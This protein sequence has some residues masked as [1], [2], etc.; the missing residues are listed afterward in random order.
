[1]SSPPAASPAFDAIDW[2]TWEPDLHA[3]LLFVVRDGRILLIDKK[4]GLGAGKLNGAGGKLDPGETPHE[5][6]VREFEEELGV[7]P[8]DPIQLGRLAFAV[9]EGDSIMIHVFRSDDVRGIPIETDEAAPVWAPVD[10]IPYDRMW[11]DDRYWLPLVIERRTF[12]ARTLFDGDRLLGF[13]ID[14]DCT[15]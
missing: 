1:M 13:S 9:T 5:A 8:I 15:P 2:E 4:R 12:E 10:D 7:R 6:A 14:P 3:T 11:A